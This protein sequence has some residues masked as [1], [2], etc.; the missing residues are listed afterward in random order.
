MPHF[1]SNTEKMKQNA[2]QKRRLKLLDY[3]C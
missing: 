2:A 3:K 1:L